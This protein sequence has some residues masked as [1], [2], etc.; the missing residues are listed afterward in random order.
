MGLGGTEA[1]TV[2]ALGHHSRLREWTIIAQ[3]RHTDATVL[4]AD[5]IVVDPHRIVSTYHPARRF[6]QLFAHVWLTWAN[7]IATRWE[8]KRTAGHLASNSRDVT[9][10]R[11]TSESVNSRKLAVANFVVLGSVLVRQAPQGATHHL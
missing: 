8:A 9:L 1:G 11:R 5:I 3:P 10:C 4:I 2:L 6:V 7:V